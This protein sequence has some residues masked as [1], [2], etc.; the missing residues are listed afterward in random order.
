[1]AATLKLACSTGRGSRLFIET[2]LTQRSAYSNGVSLLII[3]SRV[4]VL[5]YSSTLLDYR[6]FFPVSESDELIPI[7]S[8]LCSYHLILN[9]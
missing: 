2:Y 5:Q 1:M 6:E 9:F 8:L 7:L 3:G 4:L